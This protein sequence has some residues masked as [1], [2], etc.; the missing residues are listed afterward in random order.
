MAGESTP[1]FATL[2]LGGSDGTWE[3]GTSAEVGAAALSM[4]R[5]AHRGMDLFSRDLEPAVYDDAGFVEA[6]RQLALYSPRT[7][8]RVLV[9]NVGPVV[10][11]G[12]RLIELARQLSSSIEIRIPGREH[13]DYGSAFLVVDGR[14][15]IYRTL[16]ERYDGIVSFNDARRAAELGRL[17]DEMWEL[18]RPD[19][20]LRR[21]HI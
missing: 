17:V 7:R 21:L 18:A 9:Q 2:E 4:V 13:A 3:T 20:N 12:H 5:Q 11:R 15:V 14:G 10:A 16:G 19:P 6:V 8:I 1:D